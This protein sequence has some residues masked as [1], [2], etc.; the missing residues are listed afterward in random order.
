M[1]SQQQSWTT[2]L[3]N[4]CK[5]KITNHAAQDAHH[6]EPVQVSVQ[7]GDSKESCKQHFSSSHHLVYGGCHRQQ[8]YVHQHCGY[9]VKKGGNGQHENV[10]GTVPPNHSCFFCFTVLQAAIYVLIDFCLLQQDQFAKMPGYN[11]V[12]NY[13]L[14]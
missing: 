8:P 9:E 14:C 12:S 11:A 3:D 4:S 6:V 5:V 13:M 10:L 2:V 7:K 1:C